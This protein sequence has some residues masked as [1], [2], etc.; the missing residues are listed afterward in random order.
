M[1]WDMSRWRT[2]Q[3]QNPYELYRIYRIG[4]ASYVLTLRYVDKW[5]TQWETIEWRLNLR[6][7][8]APFT[9]Q[10]L[11]FRDS[12]Q[13]FDETIIFMFIYLQATSCPLAAGMTSSIYCDG[14]EKGS[15]QLSWQSNSRLFAQLQAAL[16]TLPRS[17]FF[18]FISSRQ[19]TINKLYGSTCHAT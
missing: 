9:F 6:L 3:F 17:H 7:L 14:V 8:S 10:P 11:W 5:L 1:I 19:D 18:F 13:I 4:Y 16:A 15:R 12:L 2:V